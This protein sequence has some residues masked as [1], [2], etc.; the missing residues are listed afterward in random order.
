MKYHKLLASVSGL[1]AVSCGGSAQQGDAF[2]TLDKNAKK[3]INVVLFY[4]DDSGF[5]DFSFNGAVGYTTPHVDDMALHGLRFTNYYTAQPISGAS[6]SALVTGCYSNRVGLTG[7]PMNNSAFGLAEEEETIGELMQ[8]NGYSTALIGKWHIGD[9]EMFLPPHHGFDEWFGLPYSNDMWPNHPTM[10]FPRLPLY[11]GLEIKQYIDTYDDMNQLTT[12]YTERAVDYITRNAKADKPFFLYFAEAMP[13]VPLG[14]SDKFRGKSEAGLF[15]DV[16]MELDWSIGTVRKTLEDLGIAE[17]TLIIVTSDNGPWSNYG[18]HAG[19]SGG[20]REGKSTTFNGGLRVPC[21]F[22]MPGHVRPGICN[23]LI[24][25]IDFLPT[26]ASLTGASQPKLKIDGVD[27]LP[28]LTGQTK[29]SPRKYL[30]FYFSRNSLEAVTDGQFKMVFPHTYQSYEVY[31]PG[32]DGQPGKLGRLEV[33]ETEL[34]NLRQDPGER[35][36]VMGLYPEKEAELLK[37]AEEIRADLGD[38]LT[39]AVGTG[40]REP[41]RDPSRPANAFGGM[42]GPRPQ[43]GRPAQTR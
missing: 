26:L 43:G 33:T 30:C 28:Y 36:N 17:N 13:H 5:A 2:L 10:K 40:R 11:D 32:M 24:S 19:S 42:S 29:E 9:A 3:P 6:R 27:F 41:G 31:A 34:Y 20:Y 12:W 16:M 38:D 4:L 21:I 39:G 14:V 35:R 37:V 25:S 22:Y 7:A 8:E 1:A 15:G 23:D 18:N